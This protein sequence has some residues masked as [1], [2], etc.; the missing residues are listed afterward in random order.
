MKTVALIFEKSQTRLAG[1]P[2]GETTY[3]N[4]LKT[5]IDDEVNG[6]EH[7]KIVFP[8]QIEKVASSFVQG[9]FSELINTIGYEKI[10]EKFLIE[11]SNDKLTTKIRENIY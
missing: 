8:S 1:F 11:S 4:Q 6:D 2:Y 3:R 10:E 7:I 9:F 5:I